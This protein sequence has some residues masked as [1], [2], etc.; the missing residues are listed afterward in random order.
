MDVKDLH[1]PSLAVVLVELHLKIN[2]NRLKCLD[3]FLFCGYKYRP[4]LTL[5]MYIQDSKLRPF[6][7]SKVGLGRC[8]ENIVICA[9]P[10]PQ[11]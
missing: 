7:N 4:R 6:I 8:K 11:H 3:I 1:V 9:D 5:A 10:D 2:F